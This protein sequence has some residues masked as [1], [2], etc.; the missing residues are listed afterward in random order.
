MNDAYAIET[1]DLCKRY[2]S[3]ETLRGVTLQVPR[4]SIFGFLGRNGAGKT[5]TIKVLLGMTYATSGRAAV[6]GLPSGRE[7]AG[8]E[9]RR[10]TGFVSEDKDLLDSMTVEQIIAFTKGFYPKWRDDLESRYRRSF[11]L[12]PDRRVKKLSRGMRTK[13]ALLL[14][15]CR[16][17]ELLVLDEPVSGLDPAINEEVLQS[18]VRHVSEEGGTVFLSSHQLADIDQIADHLA[19]INRGR[20]VVSG[21]LD[22]IR[23]RYCRVQSVFDGD[24]PDIAFRAPGVLRSTRTGRVLVTFASGGAAGIANEARTAGATSVDVTPLTLKEIFLESVNEEN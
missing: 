22:D 24:A 8:I 7:G 1:T 11:D 12:P 21:S 15:F 9:I 13:L 14:A 18:L 20:T 3:V 6:F 17:A 10:R 23:E 4:G 5:T 19:V 16:G 2:D